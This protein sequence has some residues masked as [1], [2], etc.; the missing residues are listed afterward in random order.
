MLTG[1]GSTETAPYAMW[2][3]AE[4]ERAGEIGLPAP[5]ITLKLAPSQ[6][7]LRHDSGKSSP[8]ATGASPA[9]AGRLR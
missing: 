2:T 8:L 7:K 5:G 1:L 3:G 6:G 4:A 9:D